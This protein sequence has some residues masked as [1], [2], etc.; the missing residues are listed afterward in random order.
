MLFRIAATVGEPDVSS[1]WHPDWLVPQWPAP[2]RVHAVFTTRH[3]GVS[4]KPFDSM[5]LGRPSDDC[6]E[7]VDANR[8][9]LQRAL[10][11]EP[12]YL[13]QVHGTRSVE[14]D[15][16]VIA[17]EIQ[18]DACTTAVGGVVC[19]IRVADCLPVLLSHAT[20]AVVGAAHAGW[21]G[22]AEGVLETTFSQFQSLVSRTS[23]L[24]VSDP[25]L[26]EPQQVLAWLG[27]CIGPEAFEVGADVRDAFLAHDSSCEVFFR[28]S[29]TGKWCADLAGLARQRL[30]AMGITQLFG[31]DSSAGWCTVNNPSRFFSYRRDHVRLGG[32]GRMAA[33]IWLD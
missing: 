29:R 2:S 18:A 27:P 23:G 16:P 9:R 20:A 30:R 4:Q 24:P 32:S 3:G 8:R 19:T 14:L 7:S 1:A 33:C 17:G 5:N 11:R 26:P 12:N 15:E 21:R 25:E 22:L 10:G 13:S 6:A 31:N 28:S